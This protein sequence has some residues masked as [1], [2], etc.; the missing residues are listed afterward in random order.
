M[1]AKLSVLSILVSVISLCACQSEP[2]FVKRDDGSTDVIVQDLPGVKD[3]A[4]TLTGYS[5]TY[6]YELRKTAGTWRATLSNIPDGPDAE[7]LYEVDYHFDTSM[8]KQEGTIQYTNTGTVAP[9]VSPR[10]LQ[11]RATTVLFDDFSS[12]HIDPQK[13]QHAVTANG[14]GGNEFNMYTPEAVNSY[15]KNGELYIRPTL[16]TDRFG[17]NFLKNGNLDVKAVWGTCTGSARDGCM[18]HGSKIPVIMSAS[19]T[20]K[21]HIR[22]GKIEVVAK[23][24]KGDW[25][26]PAIWMLPTEGHYGGWPRSGEI[27][28]MEA[29]GNLHYKTAKQGW[30]AGAGQEHATIHYGAAWNNKKSHGGQHTLQG[31]TF[32]DNFHT[33]W[34]D[35]TA[36]YVKL[37]VDSHTLIAF[38]TPSQGYWHEGNFQGNNIWANGGKDAPFDRPF[39][40]ILNVAVG[41]SWFSHGMTNSP[42]PQPWHDGWPDAM[43]GEFWH[44]RHLWWPTWHGEDVAMRI[45]SVKMQQY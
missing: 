39:H 11:R 13:W 24:P 35:W 43:M 28:I 30:Q 37:G 33:Y 8:S 32:A 17:D 12:G 45:K 4:V 21:T 2:R 26:W 22:Y 36:D 27:D 29:R 23:L 6:R 42:Y 31:T 10:H 18:R 15:V 20:S 16:T 1:A 9:P 7:V 19:L 38:N 41:G 25:L 14:G 44:A 40:L 34:I 5:W 3:V